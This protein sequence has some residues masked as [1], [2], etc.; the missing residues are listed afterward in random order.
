MKLVRYGAIGSE[1]PGLIDKA[2]KIRDL[3]GQVKDLAGDAF[4]G[5]F[6]GWIAK[7]DDLSE[8]NCKRA[9]IH[10]SALAS[11]CVEQFSLNRLKDLTS[12]EIQDRFR[13]FR[14]LSKFDAEVL[15]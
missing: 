12:I 4:A 6:I 9:V 11:F 1:K 5:G 10:G 8:E 15:V 14:E 3:S 13:E 2:G 7:T